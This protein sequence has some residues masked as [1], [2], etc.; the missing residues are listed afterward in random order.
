VRELR[1]PVFPLN[2]VLFPDGILPLRIFET[3]YID[4][5]RRCM[6]EDIPFVVCLIEQGSEV[7]KAR[8][9]PLGSTARI[10]D[11]DQGEDG[12]LQITCV[13]EQRVKATNPGV[14]TDGLNVADITVLPEPEEV[15]VPDDYKALADL[16]VRMLA[17]LHQA[18]PESFPSNDA[19]WVADRLSEL[20]PLSLSARQTQLEILEP[21]ERLASIAQVLPSLSAD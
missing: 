1:L 3:R 16:A 6:R 19:G 15:A 5:V 13:G 9:H 14:E 8:Y 18:P 12:L 7:G 21:I 4:M 20:L 17:E 2:T 10:V 11:W